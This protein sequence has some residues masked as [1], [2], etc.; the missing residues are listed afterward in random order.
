MLGGFSFAGR[1]FESLGLH[2]NYIIIICHIRGSS[3][4]ARSQL[5]LEAKYTISSVSRFTRGVTHNVCP[6]NINSPSHAKYWAT[7]NIIFNFPPSPSASWS[8]VA[9]WALSSSQYRIISI[10]LPFHSLLR[11]LVLYLQSPSAGWYT[12]PFLCGHSFATY[13]SLLLLLWASSGIIKR[14]EEAHNY[15]FVVEDFTR[16]WNWT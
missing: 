10:L 8:S 3:Q 1:Q 6:I 15:C 13:S 14:S 11:Q 16:D 7:D 4:P 5:G 12:C 9:R 2:S